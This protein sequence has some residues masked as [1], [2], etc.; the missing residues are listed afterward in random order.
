VLA[1]NSLVFSHS[2]L[3]THKVGLFVSYRLMVSVG[4]LFSNVDDHSFCVVSYSYY[5]PRET[6]A[7]CIVYSY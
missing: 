6:V 5:F 1:D 4:R 7:G 3:Q 2:L